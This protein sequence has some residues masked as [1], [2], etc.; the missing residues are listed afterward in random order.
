MHGHT[1]LTFTALVRLVCRTPL[2]LLCSLL[3]VPP[4]PSQLV[5]CLHD[6]LWASAELHQVLGVDVRPELWQ[7]LLN[8]AQ[9]DWVVPPSRS[10][11]A[12]EGGLLQT[13]NSEGMAADCLPGQGDPA[14]GYSSS[15]IPMQL[16]SMVSAY[17]EWYMQQ[18]VRD[19]KGLGV[20]YAPQLRRFTAVA[21]QVELIQQQA[22]LPELTA[23][24]QVRTTCNRAANCP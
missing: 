3:Q 17:G 23:L 13:A 4:I 20:L 6:L 8:H 14:A 16:H 9:P 21:G 11:A 1:A 10:E 18:V 22:S 12:E 7:V 5:R 15:G 24:L 19:V 2:H